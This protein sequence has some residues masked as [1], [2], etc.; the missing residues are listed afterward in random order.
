MKTKELN[1]FKTKDVTALKKQL[2]DLQKQSANARMELALSK[3]KNVHLVNLRRRDIAKL[4]TII[5]F[6]NRQ[7]EDTPATKTK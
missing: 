6:K 3:N 2:L 1:D 5:N 7:K 4:K